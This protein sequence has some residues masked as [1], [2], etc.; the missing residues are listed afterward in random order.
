MPASSL[1]VLTLAP[2]NLLLA[3]GTGCW[4]T[5]VTSLASWP[6]GCIERMFYWFDDGVV[7]GLAG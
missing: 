6:S 7:P 2:H 5:C 4:R 1:P 3:G